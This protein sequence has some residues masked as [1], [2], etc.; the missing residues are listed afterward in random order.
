MS[1]NSPMSALHQVVL[2]QNA[3][4]PVPAGSGWTNLP[5][6]TS[7]FNTGTPGGTAA[8]AVPDYYTCTVPGSYNI[9]GYAMYA[10][11]LAAGETGS[12][13]FLK[14]GV[15]VGGSIVTR[16]APASGTVV[17][18]WRGTV[19]LAAGDTLRIQTRHSHASSLTAK[20]QVAVNRLAVSGDA[21]AR[22]P[23][24]MPFWNFPVSPFT[25]APAFTAADTT[26]R[27]P[28]TI[29]SS[30]TMFLPVRECDPLARPYIWTAQTMFYMDVPGTVTAEL[31][32][33]SSEFGIDA[34][35]LTDTPTYTLID[36]WQFTPSPFTAGAKH[37]VHS[38]SQ[39]GL[40]QLHAIAHRGGLSIG[41]RW[42][43]DGVAEFKIATFRLN[44]CYQ[45]G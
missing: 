6:D 23:E 17:A 42:K 19:A 24:V 39:S 29:F 13:Q 21:V 36:T 9:S 25:G 27:P 3:G 41:T 20:A 45:G 15:V 11:N 10:G 43:S 2:R 37:H 33:V 14:N 40:S 4:V 16:T 32:A 28:S 8:L 30:S 7:V 18:H 31:Y 26:L 1:D 34:D 5:M 22:Y 35:T 12:V 38:I 44:A